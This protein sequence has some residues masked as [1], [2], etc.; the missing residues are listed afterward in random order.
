MQAETSGQPP[1]ARAHHS[2]VLYGQLLIIFGGLGP[3]G[4]FN[5]LYALDT[6]MAPNYQVFESTMP[7]PH[8]HK[9]E[10]ERERR[11][12]NN[13]TGFSKALAKVCHGL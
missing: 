3:E 10:R 7:S 11:E 9:R 2:A 12:I 13:G 6:G 5:D 4:P 1:P 8:T